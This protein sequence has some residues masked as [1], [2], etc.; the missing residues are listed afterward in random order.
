MRDAKEAW[1]SPRYQHRAIAIGNSFYIYGGYQHIMPEPA[2]LVL[3]D[4]WKY[5]FTPSDI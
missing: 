2:P 4:V 3:G 5:E 1:P